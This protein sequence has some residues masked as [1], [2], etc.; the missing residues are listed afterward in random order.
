[1]KMEDSALREMGESGKEAREEAEEAELD[2]I[3]AKHHVD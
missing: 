3:R 2:K 1:M